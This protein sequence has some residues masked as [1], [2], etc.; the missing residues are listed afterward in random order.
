MKEPEYPGLTREQERKVKIAVE[1]IC[2]LCSEYFAFP[3][4]EVHRISR[5]LYREMQRDPS[6]RILVVCRL[7]HDHIHRLPV[8]VKDQR[9]IVSRRR[10]FVRRDIRRALGYKPK[11][12]SPPDKADEA[13][14]YED[15][16][17]HFPPGSFRLS[18]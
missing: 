18:G 14:M 5:R 17:Y 1:G 9:D 7:C 2:E 3:F 8:R 15:Y 10:F 16:F 11:P 12:Y 13:V 6:A 4:L